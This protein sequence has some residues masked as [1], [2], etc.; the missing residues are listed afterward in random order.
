MK[1]NKAKIPYIINTIVILLCITKYVVIIQM[2]ELFTS[3]GVELPFLTALVINNKW[4]IFVIAILA[5]FLN[6]LYFSNK[7]KVAQAKK[8]SY[9]LLFF[10][11][12]FVMIAYLAMK[13]PIYDCWHI[14]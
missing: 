6:S 10:E 13:L 3:F 12:I 1:N 5:F 8:Y 2:M 14:V 4:I 11:I 9:L 7:I